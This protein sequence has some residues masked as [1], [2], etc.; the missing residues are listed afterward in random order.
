M[1]SVELAWAMVGQQVVFNLDSRQLSWGQGLRT[2]LGWRGWQNTW[3]FT[4]RN[5]WRYRIYLPVNHHSN[6]VVECFGDPWVSLRNY[7]QMVDLSRLCWLECIPLVHIGAK[8]VSGHH[9][10]YS[11]LM[12]QNEQRQVCD[13]GSWID[14]LSEP[15]QIGS[16]KG[17]E[18]NWGMAR[19]H[20]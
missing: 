17:T 7:L 1:A 9:Q 10:M 3:E 14:P 11:F 18:R 13:W 4:S 6:M 19:G 2:G 15:A 5:I 12:C 16:L 8:W 20:V